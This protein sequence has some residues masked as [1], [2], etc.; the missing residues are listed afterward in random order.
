MRWLVAAVLALAA[1]SSAQD[2]N[3][4][5]VQVDPNGYVMFCPCMGRFGNQADHYLGALA[6]AKAVN[7]TLVLPPFVEYRP[8]ERRS[9]QVPF[10]TYFR[11]E[12]IRAFHDRVVTM[13]D[14]FRSVTLRDQV[15]PAER[16]VSFCYSQ[17]QPGPNPT[18]E[19]HRGGI[20]YAKSGNP[21]GPFWDTFS[22][23][24]VG[25]KTYGPIHFD[26]H[27]PGMG[28]E[29][30]KKFPADT[31]PVLAFTGAPAS[32]PVQKENVWL[33]RHLFNWAPSMEDRAKELIARSPSEGS[34]G[35]RGP[36]VALH[37]RN[38]P[39]W[40]R[41]CELVESSPLMFAA[42]QCVGYHK[43]HGAATKTMC[44]PSKEEVIRQTRR[45]VK[46]VGA[47]WIFVASD[48]DH[49]RD[50]LEAVLNLP[51]VIG[52]GS[53][54]LDLAIMGRANHFVGNCISSFSAF[55][56]RERDVRG[57]PSTFFGFPVFRR[58][59]EL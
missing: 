44:M 46:S 24:F 4:E 36:F 35:Q 57:F 30:S 38:G 58:K 52:G 26:V 33:H 56:K 42:A 39:D 17:R 2:Q 1:F 18:Q 7:R 16:R 3:E 37:L 34:G 47:T 10:D 5:D 41:A 19:D 32:F 14:F 40:S 11:V 8:G 29:W 23:T 45:A 13:E 28:D 55:V 9:V 21:F 20:C 43:E 27:H 15:W 31:W 54:H 25:S 49:M 53:P 6:F 59:D 48:S 50:H 51:V 22:V 12:P